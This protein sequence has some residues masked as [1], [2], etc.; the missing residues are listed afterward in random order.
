MYTIAEK[1]LLM[2]KPELIF[3]SSNQPRKNFDEYELK[4]LA[5]SIASNGIIQPLTVRKLEDG[6]YELIAGERRLRAAKIAGLKKV[7]CV[8]HKTDDVTAAFYTVTEN[9]QRRDLSFFEE[10]QAIERLVNE[11]DIPQSEVAMRLGMAQS[12]LSNKLRILKLSEEIKRRI[13]AASLSERHAR[14]LLT[15]PYDKREE[16]LNYIIAHELNLK[17]TEEYISGIMSP[18]EIEESKRSHLPIRKSAISDMRFFSNSLSKLVETMKNFGV[19]A[20]TQKRETEKYIE[21]KVRI[22]KAD[23]EKQYQQ[24]KII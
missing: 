19:E 6:Y 14:A 8:L 17:E 7:P 3:P 13:T 5:D 22:N 12:T 21:Y 15:V 11:Y 20:K 1:K 9:L 2:L 16:T 4:L 24:L 10:A 23:N 18:K